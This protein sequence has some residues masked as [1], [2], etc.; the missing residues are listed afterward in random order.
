[1][2]AG[3]FHFL[4]PEGAWDSWPLGR[5]LESGV[6]DE[7]LAYAEFRSRRERPRFLLEVPRPK[8]RHRSAAARRAAE[9][10][11]RGRFPF[12]GGQEIRLGFP[13]KDWNAVPGGGE[14]APIRAGLHWTRY[15][16]GRLG[17]DAR[18]AWEASRLG[19]VFPLAR[20]F[21]D[22]GDRRYAEGFWTLW[23]SW[24]SGNPPHVGLQWASAQ[25]VALRL[26]ALVVAF[27]VLAPA[28]GKRPERAAE[29][30]RA[31][32][33]HARRIPPTITYAR[34]QGNNH[35]LSEAAGL[36]TAGVLFPEARGSSEW[37]RRGR[38]LFL[39][40]IRSQKFADCG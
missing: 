30:A 17:L 15:D 37:R 38:S 1:M 36:Y 7:P 39:E 13:P 29:L 34:A 5:L 27:H 18:L 32:L 14:G 20:A 31:I 23:K 25:E 33:L 9:A 22:T 35:L 16:L 21:Y 19:W 6:P 2:A 12:G 8:D 10:I 40:G 4:T 11:L 24:S 3:A 26:L 28:W